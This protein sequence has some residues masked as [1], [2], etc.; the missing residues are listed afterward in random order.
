MNILITGGNGYIATSLYGMD[1]AFEDNI[2]AIT[3]KDF[4]LTDRKATNKW[5]DG[6]YFDVYDQ[7]FHRFKNKKI[8]FVE[9]GVF[10]GGSLFMWRNY[11]G[12]RAKV[13]GVEL[14]P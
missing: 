11:F 2:T 14:N 12:N 3:R 10:G 7:L 4:D 6:K 1:I 5:F 13:I 8:T 9:V